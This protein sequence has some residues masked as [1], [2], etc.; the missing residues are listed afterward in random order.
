MDGRNAQSGQPFST[1]HRESRPPSASVQNIQPRRVRLTARLS[2]R[3]VLRR[4]LEEHRCN[5]AAVPERRFAHPPRRAVARALLRAHRSTASAPPPA[6]PCRRPGAQLPR[7]RRPLS[8][9]FSRKVVIERAL[10]RAARVDNIVQPRSAVAALPKQGDGGSDDGLA[11]LW[12][13]GHSSAPD[14]PLY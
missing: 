6:P 12:N 4:Q 3:P 10:G 13:G 5:W 1:L 8:T 7:P 11:V 9:P 14:M 2:Y